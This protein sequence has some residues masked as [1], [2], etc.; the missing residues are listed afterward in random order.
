[1]RVVVYP[2]TH[3]ITFCQIYATS[4]TTT[5]RRSVAVFKHVFDAGDVGRRELIVHRDPVFGDLHLGGFKRYPSIAN[6]AAKIIF[7]YINIVY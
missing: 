2:Y 3:Y 1:M 6:L 7:Y 4:V 5:L